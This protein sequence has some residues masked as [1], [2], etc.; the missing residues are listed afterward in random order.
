M[1]IISLYIAQNTALF[2]FN[3]GSLMLNKITTETVALVA[4]MVVMPLIAELFLK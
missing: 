1:V 2:E 4:S 3:F